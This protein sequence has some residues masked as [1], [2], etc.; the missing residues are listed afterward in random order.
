MR[1]IKVISIFGTRPEAIK[2]APLVLELKKHNEI[3]SK[4]L[5]TAQHRQMLDQVLEIFNIVPDFDLDIMKENQS[6]AGISAL[7]ISKIDEILKDEK[8]DLVL[9]HGDTTTTFSGALAAFY[10]QIPVGHVEAGLR[11][12]DMYS[13]FPEEMNRTLTGRLAALHFSP[14]E[15]NK[16]NLIKEGI[17]SSKI[18]VTGNT[19]I[20]ALKM[21]ISDDY[22]FEDEI[23]NKIDFINK[24]VI[25]LTAHRRENHGEPMENI[26]KAILRIKEEFEDV[27]IIFPVHL[28]P[29]VREV[30]SNYLRDKKGIHLIEPLDYTPFANLISKSYL[31]LTDSGGIQEEA[32]A[33]GKPVLVLRKETE[34]PEAVEAGTVLMAGIEEENI[35]N[36]CKELI[37]NK[38]LYQKMSN[39]VNPYGTGDS[40]ISIVNLIKR[41]L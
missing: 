18:F 4:V 7:S 35:Y 38:E 29:K 40:V 37:M 10:N 30:T 22:V 39:T 33:L 24:K 16:E 9:V 17:D 11:S 6:L 21:V 26:F 2:M 13:P 32:P 19:V 41:L 3:E 31:I 23:L 1:K 8:P 15:G 36:L 14:T 34:R 27:E 5:V 25:L 28:N 12:N 20:D